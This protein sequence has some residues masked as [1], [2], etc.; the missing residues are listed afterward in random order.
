VEC[1]VVV[2]ECLV[3]VVE[4]LV[5]VVECLVVPLDCPHE[6]AFWALLAQ[7]RVREFEA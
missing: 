7:Q 2:V 5:V 6:G 3:V 4:C 1:L